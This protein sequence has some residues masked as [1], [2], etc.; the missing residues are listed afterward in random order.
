MNLSSRANPPVPIPVGLIDWINSDHRRERWRRKAS[1]TE[2]RGLSEGE[3]SESGRDRETLL[4]MS[5]KNAE[6]HHPVS[7]GHLSSRLSDTG[8]R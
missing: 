4:L 5:S 7:D 8:G 3:A 1:E 6:I 2:E